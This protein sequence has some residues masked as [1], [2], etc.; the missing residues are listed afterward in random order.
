MQ[1]AD[2][3]RKVTEA[4]GHRLTRNVPRARLHC[5]RGNA[6]RHQ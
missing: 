2:E 1:W 6:Q 5:F 3:E 4:E